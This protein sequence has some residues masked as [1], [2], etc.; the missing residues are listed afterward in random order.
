MG[1]TGGFALLG[2]GLGLFLFGIPRGGEDMRPFLRGVFVQVAYPSLCLVL[3]AL[4]AAVVI[5]SLLGAR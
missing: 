3:I 2:L 4:G 1:L 5:T